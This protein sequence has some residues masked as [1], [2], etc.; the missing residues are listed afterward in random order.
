MTP[1]QGD[2]AGVREWWIAEATERTEERVITNDRADM[3][4][5]GDDFWKSEYIHV[6]EKSTYDSLSAKLTVAVSAL[7]KFLEKFLASKSEAEAM[8]FRNVHLGYSDIIEL[9]DA[10]A[11]IKGEG[12]A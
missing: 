6:I 7:E 9:G 2:R 11:Q 1:D 8:R 5:G 10:L 12:E 4:F 3:M